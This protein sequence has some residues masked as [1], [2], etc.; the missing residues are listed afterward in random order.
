MPQVGFELTTPEFERAKRDHTLNRAA[1][2]IGLSD[3]KQL[4]NTEELAINIST[5][6]IHV[7]AFILYHL[8]HFE[9]L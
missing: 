5:R 3:I 8:L 2:V 1:T 9:I 4:I 7:C 6:Y